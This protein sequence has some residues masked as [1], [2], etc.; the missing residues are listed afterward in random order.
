MSQDLLKVFLQFVTQER[1][2]WLAW[3]K[4]SFNISYHSAAKLTH[5][6]IVYG[7]SPPTVQCL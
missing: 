3:A 2:T 6:E 4:E 1:A 5:F 7:Q